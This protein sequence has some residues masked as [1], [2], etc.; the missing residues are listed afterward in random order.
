MNNEMNIWQRFSNFSHS[1]KVHTVLGIAALLL[2]IPVTLTLVQSQ[3][4]IRQEA[5]TSSRC[6]GFKLLFGCPSPTAA[7]TPTIAPTTTTVPATTSGTLT[8]SPLVTGSGNAYVIPSITFF[9]GDANNDKEI[10]I[11]DYSI[12]ISCF[13]DEPS[14]TDPLFFGSDLNDDSYVN[15]IDLN[16]YL[17]ELARHFSS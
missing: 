10:N 7:A 14:C 4:D 13:N 15:V 17:R 2:T 12:M 11:L 3:Q 6:V 9:A 16:L 5:A 1:K 8:P